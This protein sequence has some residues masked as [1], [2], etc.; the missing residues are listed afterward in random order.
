MA[1]I[2]LTMGLQRE[3]AGRGTLAI[4]TLIV[5]SA[6]LDRIFFNSTPSLSSIIG[7]LIIVASAIWVV[8][9]YLVVSYKLCDS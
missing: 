2:F 4:Y 5:F 3:T 8:V 1:Q 6:I 9:S 7:T